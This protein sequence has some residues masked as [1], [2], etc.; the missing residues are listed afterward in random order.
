MDL[1]H[2]RRV[3]SKYSALLRTHDVHEVRHDD[4][5]FN[6][7]SITVF[8]PK[9][10]LEHAAWMCEEMIRTLDASEAAAIDQD[11]LHEKVNRWL[12]FVQGILWVTGMRTIEQMR[13][14]NRTPGA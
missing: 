7:F 11:S 2:L 8:S 10:R 9:R 6:V 13:D 1:T 12:G 3:L 5:D 14:D 4:A